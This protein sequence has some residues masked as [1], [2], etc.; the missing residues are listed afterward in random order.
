[1]RRTLYGISLSF[2]IASL[3]LS[4][5]SNN[6][7]ADSNEKLK[8]QSK[9]I[10]SLEVEV[11]HL[12]D[13]LKQMATEKEKLTDTIT[14]LTENTGSVDALTISIHNLTSNMYSNHF[15]S[16]VLPLLYSKVIA[17]HLTMSI[18]ENISAEEVSSYTNELNDYLDTSTIK[19]PYIYVK[20]L[21]PLNILIQTT[22]GKIDTSVSEILLLVEEYAKP[23]IIF[24]INDAYLGY[25]L[26]VE[27]ST[28]DYNILYKA[29][30]DNYH[31]IIE[32]F[33][34]W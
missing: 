15:S 3:V 7:T 24:K 27:S 12:T 21:H 26:L 13:E 30:I 28:Y 29:N 34:D 32:L 4:S 9:L 16:A 33:R 10:S 6:T 5:C 2:I 25:K 1:M 14:S 8:E 19:T 17:N 18:Y 22:N 23:I 31:S 11:K 20:L